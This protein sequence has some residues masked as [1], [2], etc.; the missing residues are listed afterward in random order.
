MALIDPVE[1]ARTAHGT[2]M[3]GKNHRLALPQR[4]DLA[5]RLHAWPL[6]H[7][8]ELAAGEVRRIAQQDGE[9]Q[10]EDQCAVEILVQ[11]IVVAGGVA[12]D[13]RRRP[14]LAGGVALGQEIVERR[15]KPSLF[16][17]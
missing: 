1:A 3:Y 12:E 2:M 17:Q 5:L 15:R 8:E 7:Q 10:R 9:L 13:E 16:A 4:H 6:L 14:R 11:T